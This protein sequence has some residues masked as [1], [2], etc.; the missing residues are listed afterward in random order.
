MTTAEAVGIIGELMS[1]IGGV[2]GV[3]CLTVALILRV[4]HRG[5]L[6]V[7]VAVVDGLED[8]LIAIWTLDGRTYSQAIEPSIRLSDVTVTGFVSPRRPERITFHER[9]HAERL[10]T[11]LAII[12]LSTGLAGFIVSAGSL[13]F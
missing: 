2:I 5:R 1:W 4:A 9:S 6:P 13:L 10:F 7:E 8:Q 3:L 12:M 11:V